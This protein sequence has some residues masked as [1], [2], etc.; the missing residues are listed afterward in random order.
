MDHRKGGSYTDRS[1]L[2]SA[3]FSKPGTACKTVVVAYGRGSGQCDQ[4]IIIQEV[5]TEKYVQEIPVAK[6]VLDIC[7][8]LLNDN[9]Y[10]IALSETEIAVYKWS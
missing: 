8:A 7:S 3:I 4:K 1:F 10:V 6:P 9:H 2:R 5:G